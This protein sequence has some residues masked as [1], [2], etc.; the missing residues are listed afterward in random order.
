[1]SDE[2]SFRSFDPKRLGEG[3]DRI[4]HGKRLVE[5]HEPPPLR[6][7]QCPRRLPGL[8]R[9]PRCAEVRSPERVGGDAL[10]GLDT[11]AQIDQLG[12]REGA[13]QPPPRVVDERQQPAR[14]RIRQRPQEYPTH[15]REDRSVDPNPNASVAI[16]TRVNVGL[17]PRK[18]MAPRTSVT[19]PIITAFPRLVWTPAAP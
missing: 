12:L 14:F 6:E 3:G 16:A 15:N 17:R 11:G 5:R 4:R 8:R 18:L 13:R 10:Q 2:L 1:V 19:N 9:P 7:A